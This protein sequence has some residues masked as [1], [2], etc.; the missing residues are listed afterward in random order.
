MRKLLALAEPPDAVF[1]ASDMSA[2]GAM[3]ALRDLGLH[4]P[5]DVAIVGYDDILF[6]SISSPT[7]T[8]VRQDKDKIGESACAALIE[9]IEGRASALPE[10]VFPVELIVRE[11]CGGVVGVDDTFGIGL[12]AVL[13]RD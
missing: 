13:A 1:S 4:V 12:D 7:L 5:D 6:A 11:S 9:L 2:L 3:R 10:I 8:T